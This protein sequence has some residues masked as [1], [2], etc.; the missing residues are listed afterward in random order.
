MAGNAAHD[1]GHLRSAGQPRAFGPAEN[2]GAAVNSSGWEGLPR[3]TGDG[4]TLFFDSDRPGGFGGYDIWISTRRSL[5][6]PF[7]AARNLGAP[8]NTAHLESGP[9][10]AVDE[11]LLF[12]MSDRP[13]GFGNSDLWMMRL[14]RGSRFPT[15]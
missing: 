11:S 10:L 2:L 1:R 5:D 4:L 3:V 7:G 8:V 15:G 6:E 14:D 13:G 9:G 12:F